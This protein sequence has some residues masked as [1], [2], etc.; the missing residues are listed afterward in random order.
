[1]HTVA[2]LVSNPTIAGLSIALPLYTSQ[3][4]GGFLLRCM[5]Y[6]LR[7]SLHVDTSLAALQEAAVRDA[8][9]RAAAILASV[10]PSK[11]AVQPN[12]V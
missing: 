2:K 9:D 3:L 4:R 5:F 7:N 10:T 12:T 1:M 8:I 11:L 6:K